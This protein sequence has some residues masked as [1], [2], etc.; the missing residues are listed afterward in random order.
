MSSLATEQMRIFFFGDR[1]D[2]VLDEQI[3]HGSETEVKIRSR[4]IIKH[5][6]DLDSQALLLAHNH[7]SGD[8]RPSAQDTHFTRV[9]VSMCKTLEI[10]VLDHM[11]VS[12]NGMSSFVNL[13]LM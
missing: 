4:D 3:H 11:I 6:F 12:R 7:P 10:A 2:L 13:G 5:A 1:H 9:F 8:H